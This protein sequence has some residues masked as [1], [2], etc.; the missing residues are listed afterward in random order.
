VDKRSR[1]R[2]PKRDSRS[3]KRRATKSPASRSP[4]PKHIRADSASPV[5]GNGHAGSASP[6]RERDS[7]SPSYGKDR[8]NGYS[9]GHSNGSVKMDHSDHE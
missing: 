9:N 5:R 4:S 6:K 3:P 1:T 8:T 2:S 7:R